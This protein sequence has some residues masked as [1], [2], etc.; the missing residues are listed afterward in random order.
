MTIY[1]RIA[2]LKPQSTDDMNR[3]VIVWVGP[4][5][6]QREYFINQ[7]T[8]NRYTTEQELK[9]N[10]DNFTQK[11]FGYILNDVYFHRN[12]DG[13]WAIAIGIDPPPVWPEDEI[14]Q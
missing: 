10:L 8:L 13:T 12:R 7:R 14:P 9:A 5:N 6:I 1:K 4:D 11:S 3:M 2:S